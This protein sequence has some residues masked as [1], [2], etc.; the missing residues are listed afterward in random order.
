MK[1]PLLPVA[2]CY[3]GGLLTA[4][5]FQP[6]LRWLYGLGFLLAG[7]AISLSRWRFLLLWPLIFV[8]G[9]INLV[10]T[11]TVM[12]PHDLR[13]LLAATSQLVSIRGVLTT[14]PDPRVRERNGD[15]SIRT[16]AELQVTAVKT[17]ETWQPATGR[18]AISARGTL[19]AAY[20]AGS[21]VEITGVIAPPPAPV[22][23]GLFDYRR[24]LAQQG[25][26][27][28]LQCEAERDWK[29]LVA[30]STP[31]WSDRFQAW[32]QA[33]LARGLPEV[34]EPVRLLYA[35]TLG[36]RT[37]LS[38]EVSEPF[39]RSGTLHIFAIS[40]LHIALIA[41]ILIALLRVV[42][43]PRAG[44]GLI[45]IPLLWAYTAATG[46]QSSA[47][48]ATLMMTIIIGGWALR[49][50]TDLLNSLA[51]AAFLILLW[52]PEQLFQA[53][54]QL[55]FCVVLSIA[56]LVPPLE[57]WRDRLLALDPLLVPEALPRWQ[58]IVRALARTGLTTL[59][60][61][62][63][64]WLGSLPLAA[65]YFHLFTPVALVA[66]VV[67]VPLSSLAL[68]AALGS[69]LCGAWWPWASEL[70]NHAAWA[71]MKT[72][73]GVSEWSAALP[74]AYYYVSAPAG[75]TMILYYGLLI[76][77]L[78][79]WLWRAEQLRRT[80][81]AL[82]LVGVYYGVQWFSH[83][84]DVTLTTLPL[85]GGHA[86]FLTAPGPANDWLVDCGNTNSYQLV[87][88]P[89]LRAQGINRLSHFL[90]THGDLKHIGA[91]EDL[92]ADFPNPNIYASAFRFRSATYRRVFSQFQAGP[93]PLKLV[94]RGD[95]LGPWEILHPA[96][97][98]KA[99]HADDGA[100]VRRATFHGVTVLCLADLGQAGQRLLL[101]RE[102][103]RLRAAIVSSGL[104][105][106]SE[107]LHDALL[108]AI[109][110]RVVI[111]ADA[112]LPATARASTA[113]KQ[114]LERRNVLVLSTR[115]VGA[116]RIRFTPAACEIS[117][118]NGPTFNL[119]SLPEMI[120]L[121]SRAEETEER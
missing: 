16:L 112:E 121:A 20:S 82:G 79:G 111:V 61:S 58:Q 120:P 96:A 14:T 45:L 110:P 118:A 94:Q 48:R 104:P 4:T 2:I 24:F 43:V 50:P 85:D 39:M 10:Q 34:D 87:T 100:L 64:A 92:V 84:Q 40:G 97:T 17:N 99:N 113:L 53:S 19:P 55:S 114:R 90:L 23:P 33:T 66:N 37:A 74:G 27:F 107:P 21:P 22:A 102:S 26:Y 31:S 13:Q 88:R 18:L 30:E 49:R 5:I 57:R 69:L 52:A 12:A 35:M 44:C 9:W 70:F 15:L 1:R 105:A 117:T 38:G 29:L 3:A 6:D 51:A 25:I 73:A 81:L 93:Q 7:A 47:V 86:E 72:M 76:G 109:Q 115:E 95:P 11:R 60:T 77:T 75:F 32:A 103:E 108:D 83:R 42:R 62:L 63:A 98:D 56:L 59:A 106:Q 119:A 67:I 54:F 65:Y 68:A 101:E 41:G 116:V 46:W 80:L 28:Q 78:S 71:T 8:V 89:F 36:W 91:A